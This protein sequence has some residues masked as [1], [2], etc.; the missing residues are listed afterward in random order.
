MASARAQHGPRAYSG[1]MRTWLS[2][3]GAAKSAV[4]AGMEAGLWS[5]TP[6]CRACGQR[7]VSSARLTVK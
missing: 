5:T 6:K 7:A 1:F 3:A 2:R 4:K